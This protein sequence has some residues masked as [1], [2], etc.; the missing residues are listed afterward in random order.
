MTGTRAEGLD[1]GPEPIA[2]G[3]LFDLNNLNC[4][5]SGYVR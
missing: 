1:L 2:T 5:Q 3:E 4:S